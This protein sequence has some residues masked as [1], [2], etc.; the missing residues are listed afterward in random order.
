MTTSLYT[1][2]L[3]LKCLIL[4]YEAKVRARSPYNIE[5][6]GTRECYVKVGEE[7]I[8]LCAELLAAPCHDPKT[9]KSSIRP[10]QSGI[11]GINT[12]LDR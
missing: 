12:M 6:S 7:K 10:F 4:H 2:G 9:L 1:Q 8:A 3:N 11:P 5:T